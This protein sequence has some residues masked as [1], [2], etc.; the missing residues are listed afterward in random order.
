ML[1]SLFLGV[2][3]TERSALLVCN[4]RQVITEEESG[5]WLHL[6][7]RPLMPHLCELVRDIKQQTAADTVWIGSWIRFALR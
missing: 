7:S 5:L 1:L 4:I 2:G 3:G 6:K